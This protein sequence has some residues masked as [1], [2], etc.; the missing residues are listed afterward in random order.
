MKSR[1]ILEYNELTAD[2]FKLTTLFKPEPR[3]IKKQ[4]DSLIE[5]DY[6]KRDEKKRALL[7][8]VPWIINIL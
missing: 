7:I 5:R 8:Y 3:L 4:I 1:R 6:M 2:V